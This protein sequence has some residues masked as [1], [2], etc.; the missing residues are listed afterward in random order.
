MPGS[1]APMST[2][3]GAPTTFGV[4]LTWLTPGVVGGSEEYAVRSLLGAVPHLDRTWSVRIYGPQALAATHPGLAECFR[5]VAMPPVPGGRI[6]RIALEQTWLAAVS[7]SD[8][9]VH[10]VGGTVPLVRTA[11]AVVTVHDLQPIDLPE[12]FGAVKRRWLGAMIPHAAR[13][14]ELVVCPSRFTADRLVQRYGIDRD[15]LR[16]VAHAHR[17]AETSPETG[18]ATP[19]EPG[20]ATP[21]PIDPSSFGRFLLYPAI[22]YPHKRH[23]DLIAV[24]DR[25]ADRHRDLA[26]VLTGR[27]GPET[28]TLRA[29]ADRLGLSSRVHFTGRIPAADVDR[30]Y[31]AAV[32][33][34]FPSAYEGF[35]NPALEAMVHGRPLVVSD[36]GALPEVV[37][38]GGIVVP[39]GDI[40]ALAA[41]VE[42]VLTD[43]SLAAELGRR[44]RR[45]ARDFDVE[46]AGTALVDVYRE[47]LSRVR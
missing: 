4:N 7:R 23:I 28:A 20:A 44:G 16:V 8:R 6:S 24:L 33:V 19:P 34:V 46:I 13:S 10:H 9:F 26:L 14:S 30:L 38:D 3:N 41:A 36:A 32:A 40:G 25:L 31:R 37:G 2:P 47:M 43:P 15:R 45:R 39:V 1:A 22:A 35:G 18:V 21:S 27:D 29:E 5:F 17:P 12:H 42:K 11:P